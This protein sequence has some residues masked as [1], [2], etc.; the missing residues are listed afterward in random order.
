MR[1]GMIG[2]GKMGGNMATRLR[3]RGHEVVGFDRDPQLR[4]VAS[5]GELVAALDDEPR[6]VV[7]VMVPS[8]GPTE[9]TIAELAELLSPDDLI[10]DGG[11]SNF[12]HSQQHAEELATRQ[13]GF[14]DAGVSGGVWGLDE[15]YCIMA[16]GDEHDIGHLRP[17]FEALVTDD[18]FAHVGPVGAG[19]FTKMVHNGI[20]YGMMQSLA[21]G[22]ELLQASDLDIDLPA[23]FE[24]W[25]HGSVVRSWLLDLFAPAVAADPEL[26]SVAGWAEDS[27]EGRWTVE[28]AVELAVPAPAI[29]AAL[30]ARFASRQEDP[31]AMKAIA[32]M[33]NAFG[34]HE[35]R[36]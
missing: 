15:G 16:G 21:E 9:Q 10:V 34:G 29:T 35:V 4:D 8:G 22:Y 6:R 31:P 26:T 19:H 11:N 18:G 1:I 2:L 14:I 12:R 7:W 23:A 17:V 36:S 20:E 3:H 5:L 13:I 30:F 33:R 27:G 28:Q 24:V 32:V 25:R